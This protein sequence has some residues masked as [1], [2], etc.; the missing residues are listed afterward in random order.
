MPCDGDL[1]LVISVWLIPDLIP[2][3]CS[4]PKGGYVLDGNL[5]CGRDRNYYVDKAAAWLKRK[6]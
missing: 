1:D 2:V 6:N 3:N 5:F 4:K